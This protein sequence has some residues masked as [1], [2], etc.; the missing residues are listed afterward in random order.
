MAFNGNTASW[1]RLA[2][3]VIIIVASVS[4]AYAQLCGD[5]DE[6]NDWR[7]EHKELSDKQYTTLE[8]KIDVLSGK[9]DK[10]HVDVIE[11]KVKVELLYPKEIK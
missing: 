11:L 10:V 6:L 9:L 8:T 7:L 3:A 1:L 4:I 2:L 5:I